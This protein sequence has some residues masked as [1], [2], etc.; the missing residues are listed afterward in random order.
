VLVGTVKANADRR[1]WPIITAMAILLV[2]LAALFRIHPGP[3]RTA[4]ISSPATESPVIATLGAPQ[5]LKVKVL[6]V[7]P[8]DPDAFTQGLLLYNGSLFESTG[9]NG[10]SSLREVNPR[11]GEVK[12]KVDLPEEYFGEGLA[13]AGSRLFQLTWQ[14]QKAFVYNRADFKRVGELRYDGQGWGLSWDGHRLV[15]TDGSDRL[16]FRDPETF[17]VTGEVHVTLAGQA[18]QNLNELECVEGVV[19]ANVWQTDSIL[20]IDPASGK[21]TA[22]IDASNLLSPAERERTDVLNGIAWDPARKTF[23]ITGKLWPKLFEV[24]F[25]PQP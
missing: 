16:T 4:R 9:Q 19:Y 5:R 3:P 14:N 11:T 24:A 25:V 2:L 22:V 12:R 7:R 20:R 10:R 18:V 17:A 6:S 21:V 23:L 8:H 13:L 1:P 15:M